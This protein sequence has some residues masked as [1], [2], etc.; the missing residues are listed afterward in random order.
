VKANETSDDNFYDK[1][2][3]T[4]E[5]EEN[6]A[7]VEMKKAD[8][9]EDQEEDDD[10]EDLIDICVDDTQPAAVVVFVEAE[11]PTNFPEEVDVTSLD[12]PKTVPTA[13]IT[14]DPCEIFQP[15][16]G[17]ADS[18]HSL[19]SA[20]I[21]S[22]QHHT[23]RIPGSPI[24]TP[25]FPYTFGSPE[26]AASDILNQTAASIDDRLKVTMMT[27]T[28]SCTTHFTASEAVGAGGASPRLL[29]SN[30]TARKEGFYMASS[31]QALPSP[32][33]ATIGSDT[34]HTLAETQVPLTKT[35][36]RHCL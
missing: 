21:H 33:M 17:A 9:E 10:G 4:V 29:S 2:I 7:T 18:P 6:R 24:S 25:N 13:C 28:Q 36:E 35:G 19:Q 22:G 12:G 1:K 31:P 30:S 34:C 14:L 3:E 26:I 27:D 32:A 20:V 15:A 8:E 5:A 11:V 16:G 23:N